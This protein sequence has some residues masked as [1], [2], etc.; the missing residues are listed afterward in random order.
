[1]AYRQLSRMRLI[2]FTSWL[3]SILH[4]Q[5]FPLFRWTDPLPSIVNGF[6][7]FRYCLSRIRLFKMPS[8]DGLRPVL[9]VSAGASCMRQVSESAK[10]AAVAVEQNVP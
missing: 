10:G 7:L 2:T 5:T 8:N 9:P 6:R 4:P 1:L 3:R